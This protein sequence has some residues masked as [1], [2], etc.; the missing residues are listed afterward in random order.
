MTSRIVVVV[1]VPSGKS[2]GEVEMKKR[3]KSIKK[4]RDGFEAGSAI[5]VAELGGLRVE[6]V[7]FY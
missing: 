6:V 4:R 1:V 2:R 7:A 5:F 3:K